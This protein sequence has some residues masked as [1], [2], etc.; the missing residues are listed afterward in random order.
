M[1]RM[2]VRHSVADFA[3]W[4]PEYDAFDREGMGV[5]DHAVYQSVDDPNDV[6]VWHDFENV[7]AARAL[8]GSD[9]LREAM[10]RA[11]VVGEPTIWFT[12]QA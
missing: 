10:G 7:E 12:E 9:Q 5:T 8:A 2:F 4:K 11:G 3:Q 1:V 6:T